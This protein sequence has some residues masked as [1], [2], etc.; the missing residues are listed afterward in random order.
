MVPRAGRMDSRGYD[1][2]DDRR[3]LRCIHP[4]EVRPSCV[5]LWRRVGSAEQS[6]RLSLAFRLGPIRGSRPPFPSLVLMPKAPEWLA[7]PT[8]IYS[9]P[10]R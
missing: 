5:I 2:N 7:Q 3:R 1:G 6:I 4:T 8:L 9:S 10:S